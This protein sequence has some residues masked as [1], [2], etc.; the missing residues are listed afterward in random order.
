MPGSAFFPDEGGHNTMRLNFSYCRPEI[1][2]EG[3]QRL[4]RAIMRKFG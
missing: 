4:A 2:R 1:I 3:I